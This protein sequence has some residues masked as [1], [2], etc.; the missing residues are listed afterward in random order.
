LNGRPEWFVAFVEVVR[1]SEFGWED[2]N[3]K[4]LCSQFRNPLH[5]SNGCID[6]VNRDLITDD[7]PPR[8][9]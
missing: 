5:L 6:V 8:V 3:L 1:L 7:E 2:G 9:G 4:R